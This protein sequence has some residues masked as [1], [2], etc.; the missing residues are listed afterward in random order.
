MHGMVFEEVKRGG[1]EWG[2]FPVTISYCCDIRAAKNRSGLKHV[3]AEGTPCIWRLTT[4]ENIQILWCRRTGALAETRNAR[5]YGELRS[6][7]GRDVARGRG[8]ERE[9]E[10][11]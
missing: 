8:Y 1:M 7:H 4:M 2:W 10:G 6:R 5:K 3:V 9:K 11:E